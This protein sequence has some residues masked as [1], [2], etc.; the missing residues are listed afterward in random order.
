MKRP[1]TTEEKDKDIQFVE[2]KFIPLAFAA[3]DGSNGETG[4]KHVLSTWYW[5]Q[6]KPVTSNTVYI[7]PVIV[8]LLVFGGELLLIRKPRK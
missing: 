8:G 5:I 1:L 7:I 3:W 6:M 2:G 4:S